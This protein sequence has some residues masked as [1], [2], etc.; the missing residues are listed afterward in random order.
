MPR[1]DT[2]FSNAYSANLH[3]HFW[4]YFLECALFLS[5][6]TRAVSRLPQTLGPIWSVAVEEVFYLCW[7]LFL[8]RTRKYVLFFF[9]IVILVILA[10]NSFLLGGEI[11]DWKYSSGKLFRFCLKLL[12]QYRI[13]CMAIGGIGAYLVVYG[14]NKILSLLYRK[15]FQWATYFIT[16]G[17]L[18]IRFG[19][20]PM[21]MENIP[22]FSYEIYS[23]LFAIIIVNL[24]TNPRS[25]INLNYK[26]MSYL[27]K[28]SYGL[29]MYHPIMRILA[30][31]LTEHL[32]EGK[33]WN[34][35]MDIML[36]GLTI[37][38]TI[39]IEIL[40]YEFFEK[41]LLALSK[42]MA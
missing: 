25:V 27:G 18:F 8:K 36:Y 32:F 17:L 21:V 20:K 11:F 3:Q 9:A 37:V 38:S 12:V 40:S 15:D 39:F 28:T 4:L 5:P 10:R 7:P 19:L 41:R 29:Y 23:V 22:S 35:Q 2:Y 42:R 26:W 31:E 33:A 1:L 30:F 13:S 14:K 16:A 34:W 24:A 6:L